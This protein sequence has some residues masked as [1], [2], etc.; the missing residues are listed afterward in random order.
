MRLLL[1]APVL[2]VLL[3]GCGSPSAANIELRKQ[4]Q[5]LQGK[6][7]QLQRDLSGANAQ[8]YALEKNATTVPVLPESRL[9]ELITV[10]G[11]KIVK[12]TG[13]GDLNPSQ[14]G[15]EGLK[16]FVVPTDQYAQPIKAAGS[17]TVDAYDLQM[18]QHPH[19]G[20]WVFPASTVQNYWYSFLVLYTYILPCPWTELPRHESITVHVTFHDLLTGR[21][22]RAERV[23]KVQP[24]ATTLPTTMPNTASH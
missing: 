17:F 20:H 12:G 14:P 21:Q 18:P 23:V 10:H 16:V 24:W 11:L 15:D 13:P 6:I 1:L 7:E 5:Q 8:I 19:I 4:N 3:V 2:L 22:F 9:K